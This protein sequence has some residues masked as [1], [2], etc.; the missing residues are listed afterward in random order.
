MCQL[1]MLRMLLIMDDICIR[2]DIPYWLTAGTLIGAIR[3]QGFIPWDCDVDVGMRRQDLHRFKCVTDELP[4]DIFFQ[5]SE[6]DPYYPEDSIFVKLRDRYSDYVE[7]A[8]YNPSAKWHNGLQVDLYIY[9]YDES[10]CLVNPVKKTAYE[11]EDIFPCTRI[12]F[13][14]SAL[15]V[16]KNYHDYIDRRYPGYMTLPPESERK[17]VQGFADPLKPCDH[18][19]SL[20]YTLN[21]DSKNAVKKGKVN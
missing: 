3:H 21:P 9:D 11:P 2:H 1:V 20:Q 10:G 13:A 16:P 7:W 19:E 4:K 6:T 12:E 15:M 18:P 8:F 14:G 5:D 17:P